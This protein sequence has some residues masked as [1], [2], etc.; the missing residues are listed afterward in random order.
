MLRCK[1]YKDGSHYIAIRPTAGYTGV[2]RK[3]P[4]EEPIIVEE[5]DKEPTTAENC[6]PEPDIETESCEHE[7][8]SKDNATVPDRKPEIRR[9]VSTRADEFLRLY[10]E[11]YG[12]KKSE[13]YRYIEARLAPYFA[14]TN[15]LHQYIDK[16]N[17]K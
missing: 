11:S 2:R 5:I 6:S 7:S 12:M 14:N 3:T 10:R 9:R 1:V 17:G 15:A 4:P 13:Q 16:K 8:E